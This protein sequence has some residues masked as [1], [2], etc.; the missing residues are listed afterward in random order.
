MIFLIKGYY[1][2]VQLFG[3]FCR[4]ILRRFE[5]SQMKAYDRLC[6]EYSHDELLRAQSKVVF[7]TD[8]MSNTD[9]YKKYILFV[10]NYAYIKT[11]L[12]RY[13]IGDIS[14][15]EFD[16][17]LT[18]YS[19]IAELYFILAYK[20]RGNDQSNKIKEYRDML[21]SDFIDNTEDEVDQD[22]IDSLKKI[23]LHKLD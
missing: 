9:V 14:Y 5:I 20:F 1:G 10:H 21:G 23:N 16:E 17:I 12:A 2:L 4:F 13:Y 19:R 7:S 18:A 22:F 6:E 15:G 3:D 8:I 11:T